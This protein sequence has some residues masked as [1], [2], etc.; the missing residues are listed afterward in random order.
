LDVT[1]SVDGA[2]VGRDTLTKPDAPFDLA[3]PLPA[4]SVGKPKIE[5]A[6]DVDHTFVVPTDGRE[7]GLVFGTISIR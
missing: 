7:L 2:A 1:V 6:I 3:Y 5:V 4:Q